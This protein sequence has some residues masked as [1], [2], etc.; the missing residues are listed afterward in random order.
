V[1]TLRRGPFRAGA[2]F[3]GAVQNYERA[4]GCLLQNR[5]YL[6]V[7]FRDDHQQFSCDWLK[8]RSSSTEGREN[9]LQHLSAVPLV[10]K[11]KDDFIEHG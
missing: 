9:I 10:Y 4:R 5:S 2:L 8:C 7:G 6:R 3:S 1:L 11:H